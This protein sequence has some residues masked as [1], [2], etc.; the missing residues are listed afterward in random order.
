MSGGGAVSVRSSVRAVPALLRV[1]VLDAFAY[2][3]EM[4]VWILTT[5]MPLIML[6]LFSAV[7]RETPVGGFDEPRLVAYFLATFIVRQLTSSWVSWQIN[8]EVRDG[9]LAARL[10]R[11][12]HPV[13]AYATESLATVPL[14]AVV[15]LP[16][17]AALLVAVGA[18]QLA[19]DRVVWALWCASILGAW[20]ISLLVSLAI[21]ALAFFME[22]SARLTDLWL[23]MY[24]VFSGYLVPIALFPARLRAVVD[25]LPFRYQIGLP[26]ELMTGAHGRG[27]ALALVG[28]QWAFALLATLVAHALWR[29][30]LARFAAYGG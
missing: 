26:V 22:Q 29:R 5:T 7:A 17:T 3:G 24:F 6:A 8:V 20:L 16:V 1:G 19:S 13:V 14:R 4:I 27:E 21:G 25:W 11:P 18:R 10:V 28:R 23:T 9:T 12:V 30:G 2:R 15:S